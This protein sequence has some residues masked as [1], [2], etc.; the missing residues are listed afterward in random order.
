MLP[1]SLHS[2]AGAPN[3]GA[4][5]KA[6]RSGRDDSIRNG[7]QEEERKLRNTSNRKSAAGR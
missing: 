5:S 1:R 3:Y 2:A 6:V 4:K 7:D